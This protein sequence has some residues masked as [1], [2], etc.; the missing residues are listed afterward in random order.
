[1]EDF[2]KEICKI[3]SELMIIDLQSSADNITLKDIDIAM[4][5]I[6]NWKIEFKK[7]QSMKDIKKELSW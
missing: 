6:R 3:E 2:Y 1:M 7:I 4:N 5:I